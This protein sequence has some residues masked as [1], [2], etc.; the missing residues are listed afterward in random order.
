MPYAF[1]ETMPSQEALARAVSSIS[2]VP[3]DEIDVRWRNNLQNVDPSKLFVLQGPSTRDAPFHHRIMTGNKR[4]DVCLPNGDV[5][6]C[7]EFGPK[8]AAELGIRVMFDNDL[9]EGDSDYLPILVA[10]PDGT[11]HKAEYRE[12]RVVILD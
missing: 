8:L 1:F 10:D 4:R 11:I 6:S 7:F 9:D 3:L 5:M 2:G 12:G